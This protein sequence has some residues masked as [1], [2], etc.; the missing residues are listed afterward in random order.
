[1]DTPYPL[2]FPLALAARKSHNGRPMKHDPNDLIM[3]FNDL[4]RDPYRTVLVKGGEEPEYVPADNANGFSQ[5]IFAHGYYASALHEIS[6]W[7]IA[8]VERRT[9]RDYGYWY[10]PD[11]RTR[12]QQQ[13][14]ETLEVKP[15]ALEWL[16]SAAVGS[17]FHV[18]VDN[19]LGDGAVDEA[20]FRNNVLNQAERYL[21]HGMPKRA[22]EFFRALR[23]LYG[24]PEDFRIVW[25]REL[26][27]AETEWSETDTEVS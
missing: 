22:G 9:L 20:A 1:V 6:H 27:R 7:C 15:Q 5:I 21:T 8:G 11:G 16:F 17:W 13:A 26:G 10:C 23:T 18:S 24:T 25:Q 2:K 19:L 3:L 12:S 4:F 14:F